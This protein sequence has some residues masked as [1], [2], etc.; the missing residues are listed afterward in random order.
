MPQYS[1]VI[2]NF[3]YYLDRP[4]SQLIAVELNNKWGFINRETGKFIIE[5]QYDEVL[6]TFCCGYALV[7]QFNEKTQDYKQLLIDRDNNVVSFENNIS[8]ASGVSTNGKLIIEKQFEST[9]NLYAYGLIDINGIIIIEPHYDFM[10]WVSDGILE[11]YTT[12][13]DMVYLNESGDEID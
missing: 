9:N 10:E 5:P 13:G 7:A 3:P 2:D 12:D 4:K 11:V 1:D 8:P 6:S